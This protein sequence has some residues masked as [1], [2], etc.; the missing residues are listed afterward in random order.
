MKLETKVKIISSVTLAL[1]VLALQS[2]KEREEQRE[3]IIGA[4]IRQHYDAPEPAKYRV[5]I[6]ALQSSDKDRMFPYTPVILV[7]RHNVLASLTSLPDTRYLTARAAC[8]SGEKA[9]A[10]H[11]PAVIE[12]NPKPMNDTS[13]F[14]YLS[15]LAGEDS[16]PF[17]KM[18]VRKPIS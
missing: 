9:I 13:E 10:K 7:Y 12:L 2:R 18:Y 3:K 8:R 1:G 17:T 6:R 14:S 15:A 5:V 11:A 4:L 16:C